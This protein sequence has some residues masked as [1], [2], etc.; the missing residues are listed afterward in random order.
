MTQLVHLS[1]IL[2]AR[3]SRCTLLLVGGVRATPMSGKA[4]VKESKFRQL[5]SSPSTKIG[6][7]PFIF[8]CETAFVHSTINY[9]SKCICSHLWGN[10]NGIYVYVP[11]AILVP[12]FCY[13]NF[14]L[15]VLNLVFSKVYFC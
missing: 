2:E 15:D 7:W 12:S 5:K 13:Y 6:S 11:T 4:L 14:V 8:I 10:I 9:M 1:S 3:R